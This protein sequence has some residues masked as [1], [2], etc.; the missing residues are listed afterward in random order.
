MRALL[1]RRLFNAVTR[2]SSAVVNAD[3]VSFKNTFMSNFQ[4]I[5]FSESASRMDPLPSVREFV[6][7]VYFTIIS[8]ISG[9]AYA[10]LRFARSWPFCYDELYPQSA[11]SP[12][13]SIQALTLRVAA[14]EQPPPSYAMVLMAPVSQAEHL[15]LTE[16][17]K[18]LEEGQKAMLSEVKELR[19]E[20]VQLK[21]DNRTAQ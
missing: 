13:A 11:T 5:T 6:I 9:M 7:A 18:T 14:N 3:R 12:N 4:G 17:V 19:L 21:E 8:M 16:R 20:V 10:W 2:D 15:V 1:S